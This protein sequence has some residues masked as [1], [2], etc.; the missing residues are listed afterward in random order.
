MFPVTW[1]RGDGFSWTFFRFRL[2]SAV[3]IER[4]DWQAVDVWVSC[5]RRYHPSASDPKYCPGNARIPRDIVLRYLRRPL[6]RNPGSESD[7]QYNSRNCD[8]SK[9]RNLN[10]L[11]A[12]SVE[13]LI[14]SLQVL[15]K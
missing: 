6:I 10:Q 2:R 1:R 12:N 15:C 4:F 7:S 5:D 9:Y 11:H 13:A 3:L 14:S 8:L